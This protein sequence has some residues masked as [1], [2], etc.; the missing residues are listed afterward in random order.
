MEASSRDRRLKPAA[1]TVSQMNSSPTKQLEFKLKNVHPPNPFVGAKASSTRIRFP[2]SLSYGDRSEQAASSLEKNESLRK[3]IENIKNYDLTQFFKDES[4]EIKLLATITNEYSPF[5]SPLEDD[6]PVSP[7]KKRRP[8]SKTEKFMQQLSK[9]VLSEQN[10]RDLFKKFSTQVED[11]MLPSKNLPFLYEK[12]KKTE[13]TAFQDWLNY[14]KSIAGGSQ[15][16]PDAFRQ[17]TVPQAPQAT[18]KPVKTVRIV[19]DVNTSGTFASETSKSHDSDELDGFLKNQG[20]VMTKSQIEFLKSHHL[21][22]QNDSL[23]PGRKLESYLKVLK[24]QI[25]A[26]GLISQR[27]QKKLKRKVKKYR[28]I[29]KELQVLEEGYVSDTQVSRSIVTDNHRSLK[30]FLD[31]TLNETTKTSPVSRS[32]LSE[33]KRSSMSPAP[34]DNLILV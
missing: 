14:T 9:M 18:S 12:K 28:Q 15:A 3:L 23:R 5:N 24:S 20:S 16:T 32:R 8:P 27:F 4:D 6:P 2:S 26:Q 34:R 10:Y 13:N 7:G 31:T 29:D 11:G 22:A 21:R 30:M 17:A 33:K 19:T 1:A 25:D